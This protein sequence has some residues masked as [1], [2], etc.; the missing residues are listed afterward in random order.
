MHP[1]CC[2]AADYCPGGGG[3][4]NDGGD[5]SPAAPAAD[6]AAVAGVLSK[7]TNIGS[8]WRPRWF[9]IRGGVLA[10]WKIRRRVAAAE[11]TASSPPTEAAAAVS[12]AGARLIGGAACGAGERPVGFVHL[13]VLLS[14]LPHHNLTANRS[15]GRRATHFICRSN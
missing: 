5:C 6:G 12:T 10:Y 7:W 3:G 9:A 8:G 4:E 13:K 11:D 14:P 1:L 2:L 15:S